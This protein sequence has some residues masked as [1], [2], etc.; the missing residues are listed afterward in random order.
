[1]AVVGA[2]HRHVAEGAVRGRERMQAANVLMDHNAG[3]ACRIGWSLWTR[4]DAMSRLR[5]LPS[6]SPQYVSGFSP[7]RSS[8]IKKIRVL[9]RR[10]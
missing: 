7:G 2:L 10:R 9:F 6:S 4:G 3:D 5:A 8:S 1:M